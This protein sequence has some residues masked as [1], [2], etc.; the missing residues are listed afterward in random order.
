[1]RACDD[2][3]VRSR[4]SAAAAGCLALA[5]CG[6]YDHYETSGCWQSSTTTTPDWAFALFVGA[7]VAALLAAIVWVAFLIQ[8][9]QPPTALPTWLLLLNGVWL[10]V[11]AVGMTIVLAATLDV[12]QAGSAVVLL[13]TLALTLVPVAAMLAALRRL[14]RTGVWP[15]RRAAP[16]GMIWVLPVLALAS[17]VAAVGALSA[18]TASFAATSTGP[19]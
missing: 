8:P 11:S 17:G 3:R 15:V 18:M 19:C 2:H 13:G 1:V 16:W 10:A 14:R 7:S 5:A 12:W 6:E 4:W 9:R